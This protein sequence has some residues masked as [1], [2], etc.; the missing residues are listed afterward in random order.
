MG[1][2]VVIFGPSGSGKTTLLNIISGMDRASS[3][4]VYCN[5][6]NLIKLSNNSLTK[7]R[8][9][10]IGYVF[11][12]YGLLPS[13]TVKENVE[14]GS[15]L[16]KSFSMKV[17]TDVLLNN[18]GM[19]DKKDSLPIEL[20][21]GQ[22]QRVSIA[23]AIA[24]NPLIIFADEPTAALDDVTTKIIMNLF[25][26]LNEKYKTTFVV[27]THNETFGKLADKIISVRNGVI[28]SVVLNKEKQKFDE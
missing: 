27:V 5:G 28:E 23:R 6:I 13:L 3:G 14:I 1:E 15:Y 11:Q 26:S 19:L 4:Y 7:F 17:D 25:Q 2:F 18:V 10:N 21:G 9:K 8:R 12:Q 20:S 22:Q 16:Q 24:K